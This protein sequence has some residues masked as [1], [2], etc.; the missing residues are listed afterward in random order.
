MA[1]LMSRLPK[2]PEGA[3]LFRQEERKELREKGFHEIVFVEN[4]RNVRV[5]VANLSQ[6]DRFAAAIM[7][8]GIS[9]VVSKVGTSDIP[10]EIH[11]VHQKKWLWAAWDY[12]RERS[13]ISYVEKARTPILILHG[14][15]DPRVHP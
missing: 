13:P 10:R 12:Y 3:L 7:F 5:W 4:L 6:E 11:L 1:A 15:R 14:D 2:R 9:D 8:V